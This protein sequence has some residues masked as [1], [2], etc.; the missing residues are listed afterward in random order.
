MCIFGPVLEVIHCIFLPITLSA[1]EVSCI[2]KGKVG[3]KYEFGSKVSVAMLAGSNVVVGIE[4]FTVNPHDSKTLLLA[5][6]SIREKFGKEFSRVLVARGY[7]GHVKVGRSEVILPGACRSQSV[8]ARRQHKLRCRGRSAIEAIISHLKSDHRLGRNYLNSMNALLAGIGFKLR[9]LLR[10]V[11]FL[12]SY[13]MNLHMKTVRQLLQQFL[14][15]SSEKIGRASC[16][17]RV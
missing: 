11:A 7:R 5:L 8:Y 13:S 16:R 14:L 9:L 17:E 6:D 10:E 3:T 15:T 1:P 4:N 12:F 2:A